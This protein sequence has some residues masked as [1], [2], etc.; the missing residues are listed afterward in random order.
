MKISLI[1]VLAT[2]QISCGGT[3]FD[4]S[5]HR[6]APQPNPQ[7]NPVPDVCGPAEQKSQISN[8][9]N[10]QSVRADEFADA[11]HGCSTLETVTKPRVVGYLPGYKGLRESIKKIDLSN[12][13][14]LNLSFANP[15]ANGEFMLND[16]L[17]C[18]SGLST[19]QVNG[20]EIHEVV[21]RAHQAGV[22]VLMSVGGGVI[23][24]C[25]GDWHRL[26][27]PE[28]RLL[29]VNKL[30]SLMTDFELDGLDIDLEGILL[31]QI[32]NAG[33]YT[34][35]I[36]T[37]SA[38]LKPQG[39]LL[40]S[41]TASYVGGMIPISSIPYFDF[42]NIMSYDAIGPSWG[43]AG[44][45]HS[46]YQ[47]A[48]QDVQLWLDRGLTKQQLVLGLP[49]Y[50]YGFG[51][52]QSDFAIKDLIAL[53]GSDIL[54]QDVIGNLCAGCDYITYNGIST[55][56]AKTELAL[57]LG[58]GVMIWELTHDLNNSSSI[59]ATIAQQVSSAKS[60]SVME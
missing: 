18:M 52:Y 7:A 35:F 60:Q 31:T 3:S 11:G 10:W 55:L 48:V 6:P 20:V 8:G 17:L 5:K 43:Q 46:T 54:Q 47:Q 28:N 16:N 13:S 33:N 41:A 15:N 50:G 45:E 40:T 51:Q 30:V 19:E 25:S 53:Y 21:K 59:L 26:L 29:L 49:F 24:Q 14:H 12:V 2:L 44:S 38:Q 1:L 4:I 58:S 22:K 42:V 32:D 36:Q 27:Q 56:N 9:D 34:P 39:K 37:L 57:K 23:P